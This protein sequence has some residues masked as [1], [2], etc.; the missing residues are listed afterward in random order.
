[1]KK[2]IDCI[3]AKGC[4]RIYPFYDLQGNFLMYATLKAIQKMKVVA[5]TPGGGFTVKTKINKAYENN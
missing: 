3:T 4:K 2:P 1:M 5:V